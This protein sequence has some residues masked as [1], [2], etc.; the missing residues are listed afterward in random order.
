MVCQI[1]AIMKKEYA[2][3]P[4]SFIYQQQRLLY[5]HLVL[6]FAEVHFQTINYV[7]YYF[8]GCIST[9]TTNSRQCLTEDTV[10]CGERVARIQKACLDTSL[11]SIAT[12]HYGPFL[13]KTPVKVFTSIFFLVIVIISCWGT[14]QVKDGLDLTDVVPRG[15]VEYDFLETQSKYFGFYNIYLV[16]KVRKYFSF[17][18]PHICA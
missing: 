6:N 18:L 16:T 5:S 3:D 15:T 14:A 13:Q 12:R 4:S 1:K 8:P 11:T 7:F 10:T 2:H 17:F 9:S